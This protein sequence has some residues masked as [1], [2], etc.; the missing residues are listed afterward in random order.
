MK[1]QPFWI[2]LASGASA[3]I[4]SCTLVSP[5][6]L[7]RTKMQSAKLSYFEVN[8]ALKMLVRQDGIRSLWL[9]LFSTLSRDVPFSA[10]YWLNYETLKSFFGPGTPSFSFSFIAGAI[11]GSVRIKNPPPPKKIITK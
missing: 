1:Q 5:L 2:P 7:V 8:E 9:G 6:E 4:V 3:R 10:I 11:S